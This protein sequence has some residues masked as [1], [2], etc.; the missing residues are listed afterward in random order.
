MLLAIVVFLAVVGLAFADLVVKK[1]HFVQARLSDDILKKIGSKGAR[2]YVE[3]GFDVLFFALMVMVAQV[4]AN[5]LLQGVCPAKIG[6]IRS[7]F[8]GSLALIPFGL[9]YLWALTPTGVEGGVDAVLFK[10]GKKKEET[11]KAR[12]H[13]IIWRPWTGIVYILYYLVGLLLV[14]LSIAP[15]ISSIG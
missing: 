11:P 14:Y 9:G 8:F 3:R 2:G 12:L 13:R 6:Y 1:R 5:R 10:L 4:G 15:Q 7:V